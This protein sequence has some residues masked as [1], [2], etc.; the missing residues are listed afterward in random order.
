M[1]AEIHR[2]RPRKSLMDT[3]FDALILGMDFVS[4]IKH[5]E[6]LVRFYEN[7]NDNWRAQ[8][9]EQIHKALLLL[10]ETLE[11]IEEV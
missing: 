4:G 6:A 7:Q 3:P 2:L 9:A 11:Q 10:K 5:S 1:T 8:K